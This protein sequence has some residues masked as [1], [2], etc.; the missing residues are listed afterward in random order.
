MFQ[1]G[2][3]D[4]YSVKNACNSWMEELVEK[5]MHLKEAFGLRHGETVSFIGAGGKTTT[6]FHLAKELRA[7]G[8]KILVTTTTKIFKPAKPHV[9]RLFLVQEA[10]ALLEATAKIQ[11]PAIVAAGY[12]VDDE[13]KLIGIP[14][15]WLDSFGKSKQFAA[16]LVEADGAASRLFKVPSEMEPVIPEQ[17]QLTCWIMA[18]KALGKPLHPEWIHRVE[19]VISL[20]GVSAETPLTKDYIIRLVKNPAGCLKGV[21][22][23]SRK[24]AL[25]NQ[26]DSPDEVEKAGELGRAL[27][28][29]G[30]ERVLITSFL[31]NEPVKETLTN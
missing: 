10:D 4:S 13:G 3:E 25:L 1:L 22:A 5:T 12:N 19:R 20:L 2:F 26:A 11:P 7:D 8:R 29:G 15:K 14:A 17:S 6:L 9:D 27:L 31:S 16:I 21:P 24:I 28:Q 18:I 23:Q 30:F